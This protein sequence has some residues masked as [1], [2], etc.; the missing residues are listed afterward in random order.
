MLEPGV[1]AIRRATSLPAQAEAPNPPS[2][3]G[4]LIA[5]GVAIPITIVT[6]AIV[7]GAVVAAVVLVA[8]TTI[9]TAV[10]D[11]NRGS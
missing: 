1:T 6:F 2:P 11:S 7:V 5:D 8:V 3:A 4:A 10:T 9:I